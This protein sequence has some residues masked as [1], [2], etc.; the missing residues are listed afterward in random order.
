[1]SSYIWGFLSRNYVSSIIYYK[2]L[3]FSKFN[4]YI[5][6][7]N[8]YNYFKVMTVYYVMHESVSMAIIILHFSHFIH[9]TEKFTF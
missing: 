1:M 5:F 3:T 9:I 8:Y 4:D 7:N 6:F 2:V